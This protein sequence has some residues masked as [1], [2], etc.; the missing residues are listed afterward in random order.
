VLGALAGGA[1]WA[2]VR[3]LRLSGQDGHARAWLR[4]PRRRTAPVTQPPTHPATRPLLTI[5]LRELSG[6]P[7]PGP[8]GWQELATLTSTHI[9][10]RLSSKERPKVTLSLTVA[11]TIQA[12]WAAYATRPPICSHQPYHQ[13]LLRLPGRF[14]ESHAKE[15]Q[16]GAAC[17]R[18]TL[19][20]ACSLNVAQKQQHAT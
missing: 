12:C 3:M 19:C 8:Q 4:S 10:Q 2:M 14:M 20:W 6:V 13:P 7:G 15:Q 1:A 11:F 17:T 9:S 16:R 18:G 5:L